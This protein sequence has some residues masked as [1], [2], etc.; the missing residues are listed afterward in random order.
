MWKTHRNSKIR[1]FE[2]FCNTTECKNTRDFEK[3]WS[4]G[5]FRNLIV[6]NAKNTY[7][8]EHSSTF[9]KNKFR[10]FL[11]FFEISKFPVFSAACSVAKCFEF[12]N[13]RIL[14]RF[15]NFRRLN[16]ET[17]RCCEFFEFP[18]VFRILHCCK[19]F[20]IFEFS[21]SY[22]FLTFCKSKFGKLPAFSNFFEIHCVCRI[23]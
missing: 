22:V 5:I 18:C 1:K 19:M 17:L 13:F 2:T 8:P 16:F 10:N 20:R 12:S 14:M 9:S 23:L 6:Q 4:S 11:Q 21:N 15:G 7:E 3:F